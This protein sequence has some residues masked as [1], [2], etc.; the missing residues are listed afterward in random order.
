MKLKEKCK[1]L[2][3]KNGFLCGDRTHVIRGT[4]VRVRIPECLS[5]YAIEAMRLEKLYYIFK[6]FQI[7][8]ASLWQFQRLL[9][10]SIIL[11]IPTVFRFRLTISLL[12]LVHLWWYSNYTCVVANELRDSNNCASDDV[13]SIPIHR[14]PFL[15]FNIHTYLHI[16]LL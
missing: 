7:I 16:L 3:T 9:P 1:C 6:Y 15:F 10:K 8:Y 4:I 11:T 12:Q 5:H 13:N 2:K 14:K